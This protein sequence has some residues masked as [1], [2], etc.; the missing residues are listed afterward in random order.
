MG[1]RCVIGDF[2]AVGWLADRMVGYGWMSMDGLADRMDGYGWFGLL[3]IWNG[4]QG[5]EVG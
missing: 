4:V 5:S 3:V 1:R 2:K